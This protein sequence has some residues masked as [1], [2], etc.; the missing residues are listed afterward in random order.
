MYYPDGKEQILHTISQ[1][2]TNGHLLNIKENPNWM[3][4]ETSKQDSSKNFSRMK[5]L[6]TVA[7]FIL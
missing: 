1:K 7:N 4:Y 5:E 6:L 2:L 3:K